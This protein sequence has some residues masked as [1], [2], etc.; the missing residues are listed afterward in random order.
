M[1]KYTLQIMIIKMLI[2]YHEEAI[3]LIDKV[4]DLY[5]MIMGNYLL[6]LDETNKSKQAINYLKKSI[7]L[8]SKNAYA[9]YLL[10]RAYAQTDQF[11]T[12]EL[13]YS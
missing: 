6:Y 2:K 13:C 7:N 5:Y 8:N 3:N 9:W 11:S 12:G 10:S 1:A 4:N